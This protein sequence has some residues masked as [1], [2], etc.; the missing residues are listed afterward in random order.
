MRGKKRIYKSII[1]SRIIHGAEVW[2]IIEKD[3][4]KLLAAEMDFLRKCRK[5]RLEK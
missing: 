2:Q 3:M 1:E 4:E 5:T